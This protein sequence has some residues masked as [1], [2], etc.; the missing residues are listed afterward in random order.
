MLKHILN[1]S[2]VIN[3]WICFFFFFEKNLHNFLI[4]FFKNNIFFSQNS[5]TPKK[6]QFNG[7]CELF[8]TNFT[9]YSGDTIFNQS[10]A[11]VNDVDSNNQSVQIP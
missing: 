9:P 4:R 8:R 11:F 3:W 7:N 5:N 2:F 1:F 10:P 6:T